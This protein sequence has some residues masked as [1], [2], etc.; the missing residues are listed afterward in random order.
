MTNR[1]KYKWFQRSASVAAGCIYGGSIAALHIETC[2]GAA[3]FETGVDPL[4]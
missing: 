4:M 3:R 1:K 2:E